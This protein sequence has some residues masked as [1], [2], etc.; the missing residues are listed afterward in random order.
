M[1]FI[2][3]AI[4]AYHW[5]AVQ[6]SDT[7]MLPMAA[8]LPGQKNVRFPVKIY[9]HNCLVTRQSKVPITS[10]SFLFFESFFQILI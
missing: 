9:W 6:V 1:G 7:T 10:S 4:K 8:S 2:Q 3:N 5:Y